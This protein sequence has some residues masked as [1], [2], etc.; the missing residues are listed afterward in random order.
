ML[1]FNDGIFQAEKKKQNV[2]VCTF[3]NTHIYKH[4]APPSEHK[5]EQKK[6]MNY[7]SMEKNLY[8]ISCN[9]K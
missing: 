6:I 5:N 7:R 3:I 1:L 4:K 9:I 2:C 8:E